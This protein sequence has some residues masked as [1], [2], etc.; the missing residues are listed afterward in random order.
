MEKELIK[1]LLKKDFYNKNKNKLSKEFFTNGTGALYETIQRAHDDSD[2]DLSISEV[3]S[4]HMEVYNPASTRAKKE[5][6]YSLVNEI[7]ELE[8]PSEKIANNLLHSLFK[9]RIANKIA[10]LAS[11]IYNG[12]DADFSEI[13]KTIRNTFR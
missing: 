3:S 1:L 12:K 7:K 4:L 2:K 10:V 11:E 9:R 6:F 5:N 13:K 8:L